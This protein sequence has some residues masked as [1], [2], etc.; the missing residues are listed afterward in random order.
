M[1]GILLAS[2][3]FFN[4]DVQ[5]NSSAK[6]EKLQEEN[7]QLF[8]GSF[9]LNDKNTLVLCHLPK[10]E[11]GVMP[12]IIYFTPVVFKKQSDLRKSK[13]LIGSSVKVYGRIDK[14]AFGDVLVITSMARIVD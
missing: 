1:Q 13:E 5:Q 6:F 9:E 10:M 2:L 14:M 12:A 8:I 11:G 7:S 3:L 4:Y